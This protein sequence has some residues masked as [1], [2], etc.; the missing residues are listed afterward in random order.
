MC[1]PSDDAGSITSPFTARFTMSSRSSASSGPST[2][3]SFIAACS[4]RSVKSRSLKVKRSSPYSS[5]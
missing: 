5:T 1:S 4:T 3:P 2:K